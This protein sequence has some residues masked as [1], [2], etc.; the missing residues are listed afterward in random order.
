MPGISNS[1]LLNPHPKPPRPHCGW[2]HPPD[3]S[4]T[5]QQ[6]P[7]WSG[8]AHRTWH[9]AENPSSTKS[10]RSWWQFSVSLIFWGLK[11][12]K[13]RIFQCNL[14]VRFVAYQLKFASGLCDDM[15]KSPNVWSCWSL[16][17]NAI[18]H[19]FTLASILDTCLPA[20]EPQLKCV[21]VS[22]VILQ[23]NPRGKIQMHQC[24]AGTLLFSTPDES[25]PCAT[26]WDEKCAAETQW[27]G[28]TSSRKVSQISRSA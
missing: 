20:S 27:L 16:L 26:T 11:A 14:P 4:E 5:R 22:A 17:G 12:S 1:Q 6:P 18:A 28:H 3:G 8:P 25:V 7:W 9:G 23:T 21:S 10:S 15:S 2:A 13:L 24:Q 19:V